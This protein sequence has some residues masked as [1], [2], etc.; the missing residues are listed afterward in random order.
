MAVVCSLPRPRD[1]VR[2]IN[3]QQQRCMTIHAAACNSRSRFARS[4]AYS[5]GL[6]G[7]TV[8]LRDRCTQTLRTWVRYAR[9]SG[10]Q[11]RL[12]DGANGRALDVVH[13]V[14]CAAEPGPDEIAQ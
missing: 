1:R 5:L 3:G 14:S 2:V 9:I 13:F 12:R 10:L 8:S 7:G 11:R 4:S 6:G